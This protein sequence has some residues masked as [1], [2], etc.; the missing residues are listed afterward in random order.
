MA[1]GDNAGAD[2]A[3]RALEPG[4]AIIC[5][6]NARVRWFVNGDVRV[7]KPSPRS[8]GVGRRAHGA[9]ALVRAVRAMLREG[10][11]TTGG[12]ERAFMNRKWVWCQALE[13]NG[14][15]PAP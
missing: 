15:T 1:T 4:Y 3:A 2:E 13:R 10:W 8:E 11:R 7:G 12:V 5:A 9:E 14:G 6:S